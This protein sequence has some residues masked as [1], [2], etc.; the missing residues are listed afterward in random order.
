MNTITNLNTNSIGGPS[1]PPALTNSPNAQETGDASFKNMLLDSI[2]QVSTMQQDADHA[3][4]NLF[5]GGNVDPAEV[6]T[7]VQKADL[8]FRM[9]MQVRNKLVAAVQEIKGIQI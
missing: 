9:M 6:L 1:L 5:T 7:A 4:E 8:A 3:V 2:K